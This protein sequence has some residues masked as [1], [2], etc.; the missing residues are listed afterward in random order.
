[1]QQASGSVPGGFDFFSAFNIDG[2]VPFCCFFFFGGSG[3]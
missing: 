3:S 1:M 2:A